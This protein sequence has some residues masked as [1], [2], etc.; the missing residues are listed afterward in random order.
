MKKEELI[1]RMCEL[2][3]HERYFSLEYE[4]KDYAF[5]IEKLANGLFS[6]YFLENSEKCK[7]KTFSMI[8]EAYQYLYDRIKFNIDNGLDL[9]K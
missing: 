7:V 1:R 4:I 5:N 9:S 6:V 8:E 3:V 2:N